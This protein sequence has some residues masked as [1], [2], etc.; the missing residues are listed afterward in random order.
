[1]AHEITEN[2]GIH[3]AFY[4]GKP[5]WHKL[6]TVVEEAQTS[7]EAL[8]LA[9]LDWEVEKLPIYTYWEGERKN[10]L[11]HF[12]NV[13][14]DNGNILGVVGGKYEVL[15]N[16]DAFKIVDSLIE[17]GEVKYE[18]VGSLK[19]GRNV[20]LL[21]QLKKDDFLSNDEPIRNYLFF[22]NSHDGSK[23]ITAMLTNVR[24]VCWNT[25]QYALRNKENQFKFK[26]TSNM[27]LKIDKAKE[28][29]G[30]VNQKI[31]KIHETYHNLINRDISSNQLTE[32][33]EKMFPLPVVLNEKTNLTRTENMRKQIVKNFEEDPMQQ[34]TAAKGTAYGLFNAYT[35]YIDHQVSV[36]GYDER[37]KDENRL[38]SS[39]L[40][41]N[42]EK[43]R[44]ALTSIREIVGV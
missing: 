30:F 15:Q 19:N 32:F 34:T 33:I 22:A 16:V 5:P 29:L 35:Q 3:E 4:A 36:H 14:K 9:H 24:V 12:S 43:K 18:S 20:W 11:T 6:G 37:T 1:M 21:A 31:D 25:L 44:N 41:N 40:G 39:W 23:S 8:K 27:M 17:T 13:R 42:G 26:H 2:N 28:A 7:A 10:I 38:F